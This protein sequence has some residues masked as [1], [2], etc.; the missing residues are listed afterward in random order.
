MF[1]ITIFSV[2]VI[3]ISVQI[4]QV[5]NT[6]ENSLDMELTRFNVA[7]IGDSLWHK[8]CGSFDLI[9]K[10]NAL[11]PDYNIIFHDYGSNG[12]K[13]QD[14]YSKL[15]TDVI[16]TKP[17]AYL[18]FWDSDVSD[19]N[20]QEMTEDQI[21]QIRMDYTNTLNKL[22]ETILETNSYLAIGGPEILGEGWL[23]KP[24]YFWF[25]R[26]ML[27]DYREINRN[28]AS[29][30]N[31]PY[32]DIRQAFLDAIPHWHIYYKNYLTTDGEHENEAGTNIIA[33]MF[34]MFASALAKWLETN[35]QPLLSNK[36]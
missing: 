6:Q 12:A 29:A 9:G 14:I 13:I 27:D 15:V 21:T 19:I 35:N 16:H 17:D 1:Q 10:L 26:E 4:I 18:L 11:L 5:V 20:E 30:Y 23:G 22:V 2:F 7:L 36:L 31:V 33:S 28:V 32:V 8:P 3:I 34:A 24:Q 25:K